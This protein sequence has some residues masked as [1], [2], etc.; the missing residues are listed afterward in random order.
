MEVEVSV[1]APD[2]LRADVVGVAVPQPA[3]RLAGSAARLDERLR[4]KLAELA[5][6]GEIAGELGEATV[7]HVDSD[8][9]APRV[10]AA[11]AGPSGSV[12]ADALRTAA[13]AVARAASRFGGTVGWV[14]DPSLDLPPAEQARAVVEGIVLG[15]Y[16]PARWKT[17][18]SRPK[19]ISGIALAVDGAPD[20]VADAARRAARVATWA[21]RARD[22][23]NAPPNELTPERL[24]ARAQET[25]A[26]AEPVEAGAPGP[27]QPG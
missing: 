15:A 23:A 24:A 26:G 3:E 18:S 25:A 12:D 16:E 27:G 1:V 14:L 4:G 2:D 11:G 10:A 17:N 19:P 9:G 22:L 7:L 5:R 20:E 21:N 8:V 6:Q 13:A